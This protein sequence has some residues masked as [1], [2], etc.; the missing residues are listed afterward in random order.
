MPIKKTKFENDIL[1]PYTAPSGSRTDL[2]HEARSAELPNYHAKMKRFRKNIIFNFL[3]KKK[4]FP[5]ERLALAV[6]A[7]VGILEMTKLAN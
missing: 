1:I 3:S 7:V 2:H 4:D 6:S 5:S